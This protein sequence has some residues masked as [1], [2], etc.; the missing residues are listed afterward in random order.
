M[1][2]RRSFLAS[3]AAAAAV[4]AE[5]APPPPAKAQVA[6]P[7]SPFADPDFGFT[8][9]IV[10]GG[11]YYR[12][13][14]PGKLLAIVSKIKAGDFES[15][16][17]S[18]HQAGVES[19]TLADQA[20]AKRHNVSARE[21]YLWAASYFSAAL[22]FLDGT[23]DPE[24]M[25]P[26][27][28]EYAACWSAAAALFDPPMERVE[29]PYEGASLT[30]WF[31]RVDNS[32]RRR[33]L[34]VLNNGADGLEKSMYVLGGAGA[35]ARGYN[36]LIFNGPGQGDS[37]WVRKLYFRPDWEKVIT[38]VVDAMLRHR[39]VDPKRIALV[40]VSQGGYW[41]PRA[42]AFEHRIAAG[43]ADPGVWDVS[44]PW[45]RNLPEFVRRMLDGGNKSQFDRV[46]QTSTA[47]NVRARMGLR[48]RM[49]PYGMTSC[50]DAFH[51]VEE[52]NLREVAGRIR[53]PM[54]IADPE[55][56]QF[57]PGQAQK[58]YDAL[59]C[60]KAI[61]RFTREQGADQHCEVG[62]PGYRD[63]CIYN[64]LDETLA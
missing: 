14:N 57:F 61:V 55:G 49:R 44:D 7:A 48:F 16:W 35:L 32:R 25:L 51:A 20:A 62:A 18:Y 29:I 56:E 9:Q 31:L 50:Y 30:G 15:A 63:F 26:C 41:A 52:Y 39:E 19:R 37:L 27:W 53:C 54:L 3:A 33:P 6:A 59:R 40:G 45:L 47:S 21:A 38:P 13:G 22:R 46:I 24:R 8:A 2:N 23:A 60:P 4:S 43:V 1:I 5:Q 36:C 11:S 34:V 58:L 10:Q 64:W 17:Q 28:Q 42:L 12:A